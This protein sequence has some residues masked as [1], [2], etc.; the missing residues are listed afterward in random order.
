MYG[1]VLEGGGSKGAYHIGACKAM[2]EKGIEFGGVAGTS[3]GALNGA[4]I[5]QGDLGKAY[6]MWYDIDPS[7]VI[8]F[9]GEGMED[10]NESSFR[11]ENFKSKIRII[12]KVI[13][14][15]GINID[16]LIKMVSSVV[17]EEKVRSSKADF[18][19]VT[20]DLTQKKAVEIFKEDIPNGK[21]VDYLIASASFPGFRLRNIDGSVYIDGGFYNVLPINLVIDK[22]YRDIIVIRTYGFGIKRKVDTSGCNIRYIEPSD[23]LGVVMDFDNARARKNLL[24]GYYDVFKAF[25]GLKGRKY[26]VRPLND[27][28]FFLNYFVNLG[29]EKIS[30]LCRLFGI[31]M[32]SGKRALF[33]YIIPKISSLLGVPGNASYEDISISLLEHIAEGIG[34]ERFRIYGF[35]ELFRELAHRYEPE[36]ADFI[37]EIPGF[38]RSIELVS[39]IVKERIIRSIAGELFNEISSPKLK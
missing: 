17:D 12:K 6:E 38:L 14:E 5:V 27:E 20:V 37:S 15:K 16:P 13:H 33:E 28:S 30:N 11:A 8:C 24:L 34:V 23:D 3:V 36:K 7:K 21:L 1:L 39:H 35:K 29:D 18:G 32:G 31:E 9:E 2:E 4:M 22:G 10:L 19:I 26:Y 25:E